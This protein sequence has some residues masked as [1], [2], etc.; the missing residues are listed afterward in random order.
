M[1]SF[2]LGV[3]V[4]MNVVLFL[5]VLFLIKYRKLVSLFMNVQD[6]KNSL[7]IEDMTA[8]KDFMEMDKL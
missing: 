5:F 4:S 6:R 7:E 1:I 2:L 3:S 8:F